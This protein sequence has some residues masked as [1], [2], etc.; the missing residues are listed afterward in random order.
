MNS[1]NGKGAAP[2]PL[3]VEREEYERR[4]SSVFKD[5]GD[6]HHQTKD[7]EVPAEASEDEDDAELAADIAALI[8]Q[9]RAKKTASPPHETD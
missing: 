6:A 2:R 9:E 8:G 5:W 4:W 1:M 7:G 3:S